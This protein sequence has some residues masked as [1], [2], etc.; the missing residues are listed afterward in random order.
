MAPVVPTQGTLATQ[1]MP[2]AHVAV[3]QDTPVDPIAVAVAVGP[4]APPTQPVEAHA[5]VVVEVV[6]MTRCAPPPSR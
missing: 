6:T 2:V 3:T 5:V 1:D 4:S